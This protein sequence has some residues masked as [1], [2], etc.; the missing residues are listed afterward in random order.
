MKPL[1]PSI[2]LMFLLWL[3]MTVLLP[4]W[5]GARFIPNLVL[6][7]VLV[8][9]VT[10]SDWRGLVLAAMFGLV[11]DAQSNLLVGSYTLGLCL[12]YFSTRGLFSR[13]VPTD[14]VYL[15]LPIGYVVSQVLL[16]LWILVVGMLAR[17]MGWQ[18]NPLLRAHVSPIYLVTLAIGGIFTLVLYIVWLEFFQRVER[19][20]RLKRG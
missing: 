10:E 17:N 18:V 19:P 9:A 4:A 1:Y 20:L 6:V 16:Q 7:G 12:L 2:I 5:F 15:A 14:R 11:L 13:F 8:M 3:V